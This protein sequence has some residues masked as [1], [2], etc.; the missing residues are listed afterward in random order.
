MSDSSEQ[1]L[2]RA[3]DTISQSDPLIKLLQ[4]VSLGRMQPTDRGLRAI[5]EVW[6]GTYREVLEKS[7]QLDTHALRRLDP[8]PRLAVLIAAGVLTQDH[9]GVESLRKAYTASLQR[10]EN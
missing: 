3:I 1:A 8:E 6:L 2:C 9:A 4:Q 5:T 10:R 7:E